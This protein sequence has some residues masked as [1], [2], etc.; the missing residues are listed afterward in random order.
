MV[1]G[2]TVLSW[3]SFILI[4]TQI[5]IPQNHHVGEFWGDTCIQPV[6]TFNPDNVG[7]RQK[8]LV[9]SAVEKTMCLA[10]DSEKLEKEMRQ[11]R[12]ELQAGCPMTRWASRSVT[13]CMNAT[14]PGLTLA[15]RDATSLSSSLPNFDMMFLM[16]NTKPKPHINGGFWE[17]WFQL[18]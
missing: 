18:N 12:Q 3:V 14:V 9:P 2:M 16:P 4:N 6:T 13:M 8:K 15:F 11:E 5:F 7:S 1:E 17:A 10:Q